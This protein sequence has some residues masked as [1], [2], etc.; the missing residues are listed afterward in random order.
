MTSAS[1]SFPVKTKQTSELIG[2]HNTQVLCSHF[3]DKLFIIVTQLNKIGNLIEVQR[4]V[5]L[6]EE[7][8]RQPMYSTRI[9]LGVDEP[10][11]HVLAKNLLSKI[12]SKKPVVLGMSLQDTSRDTVVAIS[13]IVKTVVTGT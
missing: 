13:N 2:G 4:D 5:V 3:S 1:P 12:D 11:T 7:A 9:L 10:L 6:D 8:G